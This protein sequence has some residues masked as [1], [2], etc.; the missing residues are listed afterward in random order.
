MNPLEN[1]FDRRLGGSVV[2]INSEG[3]LRPEHLSCGES[4]TEAAGQAQSLRFRQV[5]FTSSEGL[6]GCL[7][8]GDVGHSTDNFNV[9]GRI[10]KG[11]RFNVDVLNCPSWHNQA[12]LVFE[13][14]V[15]GYAFDNLLGKRP[16]VRMYALEH[17]VQ[18]WF[19]GVVVIENPIRFDYDHAQKP[20]LNMVFQ[21]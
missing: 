19:L 21:R 2:S 10:E 16:I 8:F 12:I 11:A 20:T 15:A 18:G 13:V 6:L 5:R 3:F 7:A 4:A 9:A 14:C 17:H 1:T